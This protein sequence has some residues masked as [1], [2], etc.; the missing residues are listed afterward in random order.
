MIPAILAAPVVEDVLG[1][2]SDAISPSSSSAPAAA[3]ATTATGSAFA[4]FLNRA[5]A[6]ATVSTT[7]ISSSGVM[8]AAQWNQMGTTDLKTWA[9]SLM[10][11][12]VDVTDEAGRT[13]SGVVGGM[14][15]MG[16][17]Y[18]LN[19]GGHLVSLSQLKQVSWSP[20]VA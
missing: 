15:Q 20:A 1:T 10:G 19:I 7:N 9:K 4:P 11:R 12:H 5:N 8:H 6:A 13:I 18:G 3:P 2:V 17:T 16:N 14:Q